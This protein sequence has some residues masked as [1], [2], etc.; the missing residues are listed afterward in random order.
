V[1]CGVNFLLIF[2]GSGIGGLTRYGVA[3]LIYYLFG[4]HFPLGTLIVNISGSLLMG[5]LFVLI[6]DRA[7]QI[8]PHLRALLL[9]GFLGGY[10]TFS[11]F[12]IETVNLFENGEIVSAMMNIVLSV[13]LCLSATWV[14]IILG[15][16]L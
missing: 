3:N 15:R 12:S 4:R 1:R 14:G 11:S 2:I 8:A 13:V 5:F 16:Q 9:I 6:L 7:N 10:T